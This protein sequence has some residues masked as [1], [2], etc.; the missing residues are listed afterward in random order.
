VSNDAGIVIEN[1]N[2]L[3]KSIASIK[4][5]ND[6][7]NSFNIYLNSSIGG[8]NTSNTSNNAAVIINT[9]GNLYLQTKNN[10][11][12]TISDDSSI[13]LDANLTVNS[14]VGIKMSPSSSNNLAIYG[15]I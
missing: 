6:T 14:N 10:K 5:Y 4:M 3:A 13:Y 7:N 12:I 1:K 8:I 11:G 9:C 2:T 15:N